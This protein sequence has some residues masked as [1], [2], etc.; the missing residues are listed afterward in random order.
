MYDEAS[1]ERHDD[2][3]F[4]MIE[5]IISMG[6]LL[7]VSVTVLPVF[8]TALRLSSTNVSLTTATQM[9]SQSMDIARD[10]PS[11]CAAVK[12]W[13]LETT[14]TYETDPR[15]VELESHLDASAACPLPGDFP[16]PFKISVWVT[17]RGSTV[18]IAQAE[19]RVLLTS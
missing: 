8:I 13:A 4:G 7:I 17:L 14:G 16:S 3:G 1:R 19:T 9:V 11:T 2:R 10:L 6:I 12:Q 18:T 5:I 15:G